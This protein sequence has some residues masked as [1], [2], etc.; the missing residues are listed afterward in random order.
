[1]AVQTELSISYSLGCKANLGNYESG[2]AHISKSE[3]WD[4]VG[5]T[6][7]E[8]QRL[9]SE[10]HEALR[11]ELSDLIDIEYQEMQEFAKSRKVR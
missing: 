5:L 4:V 2:D 8:V 10:R 9:Y 6:A 11:N 3:K 7:D 1:M